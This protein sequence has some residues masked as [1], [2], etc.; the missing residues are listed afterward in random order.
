[1]R[2]VP[3]QNRTIGRRHLIYPGHIGHHACWGRELPL[4]P[5]TSAALARYRLSHLTIHFPSEKTG[6]MEIYSFLKNFP[7]P[8]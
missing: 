7:F 8:Y 1:M 4:L 3:R 6:P 5:D 2:A